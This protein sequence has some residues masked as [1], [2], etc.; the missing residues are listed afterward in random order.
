MYFQLAP[1][2]HI[3]GNIISYTLNYYNVLQNNIVNYLTLVNLV[4]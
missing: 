1:N 4:T 3:I 2:M